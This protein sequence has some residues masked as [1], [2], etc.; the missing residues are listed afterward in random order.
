[1]R[2]SSG[3]SIPT[4][5]DYILRLLYGQSRFPVVGQ[6]P[7][8]VSTGRLEKPE[9]CDFQPAHDNER[10]NL[11]RTPRGCPHAKR[12]TNNAR[13]KPCHNAIDC[14]GKSPP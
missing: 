12:R 14:S 8:V 7:P 10:S 3:D 2:Q 9:D 1:L 11:M 4:S 5:T 13:I 6:Y